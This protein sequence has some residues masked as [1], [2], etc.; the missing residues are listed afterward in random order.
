MPTL[1]RHGSTAGS[2]RGR[3]R[4]LT[5][6]LEQ[7]G[8]PLFLTVGG[9]LNFDPFAVVWIILIDAVCPLGDNSLEIQLT[10]E[11]IERRAIA[12]GMVHIQDMG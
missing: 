1:Y 7:I 9:I 10:S 12:S 6:S 5:C 3:I 11:A 2:I 4:N 8:P